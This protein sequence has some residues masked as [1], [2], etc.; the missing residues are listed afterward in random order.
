MKLLTAALLIATTL[1]APMSFAQHPPDRVFKVSV[2]PP[3]TVFNTGFISS[4]HDRDLIRYVSGASTSDSSTVYI[5]TVEWMF[6]V[7]AIC[8]G[9]ARRHPAQ[10]VYVYHIR[11]SDNFFEVEQ[12]LALAR[13]ALPSG[14]ARE[15]LNDLWL[16]T[17][18]WTRGSWA[19]SAAIAGDQIFGAQRYY[20]NDGHL[21][22]GPLIVNSNYYY[23]QPDVSHRPMPVRNATVEEAVVAEDP[24]GAGFIPGAIV[25]DGCNA[26]PRRLSATPSTS[27]LP[28]KRVSLSSLYSKTIAKMIAADILTGSSSGQLW[29]VPGHD[30]L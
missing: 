10:P 16:A 24:H 19:A 11:P 28:L 18:H 13:D 17:R 8:R 12:S 3:E 23:D 4:G 30:E 27:C 1:S 15:E 22:F 25:P 2:Q 26:Q 21:S 9:I 14:D 6:D 5:S 29:S 20:W 7:S